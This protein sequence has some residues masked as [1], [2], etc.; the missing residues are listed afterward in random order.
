MYERLKAVL[1]LAEVRRKLG[2]SVVSWMFVRNTNPP[3]LE[4]IKN[5]PIRIG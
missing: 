4:S 2:I 3:L 5:I 1:E